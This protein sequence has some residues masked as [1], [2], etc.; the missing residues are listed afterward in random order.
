MLTNAESSDGRRTDNMFGD[1]PYVTEVEADDIH[2]LERFTFNIN[3]D[4]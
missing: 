3:L 1:Q 4:S 2:T